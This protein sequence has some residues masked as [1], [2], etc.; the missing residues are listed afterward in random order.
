M[1]TQVLDLHDKQED[2]V[3]HRGQKKDAARKACRED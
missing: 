2:D 1:D 3:V